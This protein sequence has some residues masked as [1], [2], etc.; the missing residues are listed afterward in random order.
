MMDFL[1]REKWQDFAKKYDLNMTYTDGNEIDL[2]VS[3]STIPVIHVRDVE[4]GQDAV[5]SD[6]SQDDK[7]RLTEDRLKYV[8]TGGMRV[9]VSYPECM[10]LL[11][12]EGLIEPEELYLAT[13]K[14]V[15]KN[16]E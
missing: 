16:E 4:G 3:D 8:T 12:I 5:L 2:Y 9:S 7:G 1:F 13:H 6:I 15:E 10:L 11:L 14:F